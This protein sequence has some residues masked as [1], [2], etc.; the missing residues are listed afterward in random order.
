[1]L[2]VGG[3]GSCVPA[4]RRSATARCAI[5]KRGGITGFNKYLCPSSRSDK[6]HNACVAAS[7]ATAVFKLSKTTA[8]S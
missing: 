1:V 5:A 2:Q 7:P 3:R 6:A 4:V 8:S